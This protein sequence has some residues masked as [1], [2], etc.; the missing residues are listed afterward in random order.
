MARANASYVAENKHLEDAYKE[1]EVSI[2][3]WEYN[4]TKLEACR[5]ML[6]MAKATLGL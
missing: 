5:S 1:S 2:V 6:S 3:E 4:N